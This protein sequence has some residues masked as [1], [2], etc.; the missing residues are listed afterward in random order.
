MRKKL[1]KISNLL[2]NKKN[3]LLNSNAQLQNQKK[4]NSKKSH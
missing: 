1:L 3:Q 4:T 2:K